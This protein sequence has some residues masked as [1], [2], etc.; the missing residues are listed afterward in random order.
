MA[1]MGFP[2]A[3]VRR[4]MGLV[5]V[6]VVVVAVVDAATDRL[7]DCVDGRVVAAQDEGSAHLRWPVLPVRHQRAAEL[8]HVTVNQLQKVAYLV[9]AF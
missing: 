8:A 3:A 5:V 4:G 2:G 9:L 7:A 6:V 1:V